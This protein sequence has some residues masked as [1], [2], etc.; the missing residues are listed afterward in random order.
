[1]KFEKFKEMAREAIDSVC[2]SPL[3]LGLCA[4]ER[5]AIAFQFMDSYQASLE[6]RRIQV[7]NSARNSMK[8][9]SQQ[10]FISQIY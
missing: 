2:E 4:E 5:N 6:A 8:A 1:M 9:I 7:D 10:H 3:S